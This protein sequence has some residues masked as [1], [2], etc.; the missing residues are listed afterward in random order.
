M[1]NCAVTDLGGHC[2]KEFISFRRRTFAK[3]IEDVF[4]SALPG[5]FTFLKGKNGLSSNAVGLP[6]LRVCRARL[7]FF[8]LLYV[9]WSELWARHSNSQLVDLAGKIERNLIVL[10]I[11]WRA[12]VRAD[13]ERLV[14]SY[15]QR[16][17]APWF[18]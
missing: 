8:E 4:P 13:I 12:R 10:I 14:D 6:L 16:T 5:G 1:L 2:A 7:R 11:H 3:R 18:V 15:R 9:S 17:C